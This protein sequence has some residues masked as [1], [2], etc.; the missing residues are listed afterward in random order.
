MA[1]CLGAT[2]AK[3]S[4][5]L[6]VVLT[7]PYQEFLA[8]PL[9]GGE[10]SASSPGIGVERQTSVPGGI[11]CR[12]RSTQFFTAAANSSGSLDSERARSCDIAEADR[13]LNV[14]QLQSG[15]FGRISFAFSSGL[16][17]YGNGRTT[18]L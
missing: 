5:F 12:S 2:E 17:L 14:G 1:M 16:K 10:L 7:S 8:T 6:Y 15:L 3:K 13:D 18:Q 4:E 9:G 11:L